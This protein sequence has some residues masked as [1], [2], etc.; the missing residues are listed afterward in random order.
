MLDFV[1]GS[2]QF[3][4][5]KCKCIMQK[6]LHF[7]RRI[8]D[9]ESKEV[10]SWDDEIEIV[11]QDYIELEPGEYPFTVQNITRSYF[12]G[13]DKIP[14]CH[15]MDVELLVETPDGDAIVHD[16]F[17]FCRKMLFKIS[18]F[19]MTLGLARV[20]DRLKIDWPALRGRSGRARI[21]TREYKNRLYNQID[22]YII[23]EE[24]ECRAF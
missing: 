1:L 7:E 13:S 24:D 14:A 19:A 4:C 6:N 18:S 8:C 21:S 16:R 2:N 10:F 15:E 11:K 3:V 22:R 20:G 17:Y 9:M 23:P 12:D 5:R